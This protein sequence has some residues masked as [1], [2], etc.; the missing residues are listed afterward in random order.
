MMLVIF[1][2]D[3]ILLSISLY[4]THNIDLKYIYLL[5]DIEKGLEENIRFEFYL[6][7]DRHLYSDTLQFRT[8]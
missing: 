6:K 8:Q 1:K 3:L 5:T 7:I 4:S 2:R